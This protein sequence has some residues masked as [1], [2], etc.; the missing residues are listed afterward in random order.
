MER[1]KNILTI[2][3][4]TTI[5]SSLSRGNAVN[6][7]PL[8]TP[9]WIMLNTVWNFLMSQKIKHSVTLL[10]LTQERSATKRSVYSKHRTTEFP[11]QSLTSNIPCFISIL[12][13]WFVFNWL[14][15]S[16]LKNVLLA[17]SQLH[18]S[19]DQDWGSNTESH[20]AVSREDPV[21]CYIFHFLYN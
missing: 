9:P 4:A 12:N 13:F 16:L 15:W 8:Q 7:E 18:H 11:G 17:A 3:L 19:T 6:L 5:A 14:F 20:T 1:L 21:Y 2:A 10:T